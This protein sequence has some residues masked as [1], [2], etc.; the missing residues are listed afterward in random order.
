MSLP[1]ITPS[2]FYQYAACPH[3][4]WYDR[5]GD[6][7]RKG[8][9][10]EL[11][12]K[13]LEQGVVR[14]QE[15]L[16]GL[17]VQAVLTI[18]METAA[19]QTRAL[20]AQGAPRIYQGVIEAEIEGALWRGRPDLLERK[21]GRSSFGDWM[22]APCDIKS[23]HT[24]HDTQALQLAFYALVLQ[25][26]QGVRPHAASIINV[27]SERLPLAL[28]P[29][30]LAK[31]RATARTV[32]GIVQGEKP[33]LRLTSKCKQSPWFKECVRAAEEAQ[34]VALL[35][36]ADPR[37]LSALRAAGVRTVRDAALMDAARMPEIPYAPPPTLERLKLQARSLRDGSVIWRAAP[38]LPDAPLKIHFDIEGDPL[39]DLEYLFGFWI[40]GDPERR[41]AKIGQMRDQGAEGYYLYFLAERP[42]DQDR[43]WKEF[44]D[45]TDLLPDPPSFVVYHF[46]DY[47]RAR[48]LR[49][50]KEIEDRPSFRR[51]ASRYVD[52]FAVV[53]KSVVFP[54]YFYSIKDIAKSKFLNYHW[55]HAKA[56]GAQ[57]VF[58]YEQWLETGD[59][60]VLRD[61]VD[62]NEDD[63][64]ATEY[65]CRW[66]GEGRGGVARRRTAEKMV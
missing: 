7:A 25:R 62:Y 56:G 45:W 14:E 5:Y 22:Y 8:D 46:A 64:V 41:Y 47:E 24:I 19:A 15:Y 29:R 32:A 27:D 12:R 54:L 36:G 53:K 34:D 43:M 28:E 50:A 26:V 3:W 23:S 63:V 11:A 52:L 39:L 40:T 10:P 33:P 55:R 20:M 2:M 66:L 65:L 57:S 30:L 35:Y 1:V 4:L 16:K 6:P 38:D 18:D 21:P 44:L 31:C 42:E 58:W 17:D 49:L 61:I 60:A 48:T 37:A 13:L 59:R 9:M 51:F